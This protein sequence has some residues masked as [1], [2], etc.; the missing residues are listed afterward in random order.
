MDPIR[1]DWISCPARGRKTRDKIQEYTIS[2]DPFL[3]LLWLSFQF[4]FYA[5]ISFIFHT[6]FIHI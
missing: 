2:R 1:S 3:D 6:Y 4:C 5:G